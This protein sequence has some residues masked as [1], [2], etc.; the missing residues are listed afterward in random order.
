MLQRTEQGNVW[1][2]TP[3]QGV[4]DAPCVVAGLQRTKHAPDEGD[5]AAAR[6]EATAA[7]RKVAT[8]AARKVAAV[9]EKGGQQQR[10]RW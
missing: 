5:S 1:P 6:G 8:V 2:I 10:C 3:G 7:A 9:V 4:Y